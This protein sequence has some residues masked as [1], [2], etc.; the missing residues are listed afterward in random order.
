VFVRPI[1]RFL[2]EGWGGREG[3]EGMRSLGEGMGRAGGPFWGVFQDGGGERSAV[4]WLPVCTGG[5]V[6]GPDRRVGMHGALS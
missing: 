4:G 1:M 2:R 6:A 5:T 3:M